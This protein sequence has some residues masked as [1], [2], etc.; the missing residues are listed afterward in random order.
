LALFFLQHERGALAMWAALLCGLVKL[1]GVLLVAGIFVLFLRK[2]AWRALSMG[3]A[4]V[5]GTLLALKMTL[6]PTAAAWQNLSNPASVINFN[7]LHGWLLFEMTPRIQSL[8][9][10]RPLS[11]PRLVIAGLFSLFCLWRLA[12]IRDFGSLVTETAHMTIALIVVYSGQFFAWYLTWLLPYAALTTSK[13]L[14][15]SVLLYTFTALW[16]YAIPILWVETDRALRILRWA[17][18]HVA[19][20]ARLVIPG[21]ASAEVAT[22]A[23]SSA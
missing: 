11:G 4:A 6:L 7:S 8:Y 14:R 21:R 1:S 18:A 2:R 5:V 9:L 12:R 20:L 16:L 19:P 23:P 13:R 17:L 3:S 15:Q 22:P 10:N